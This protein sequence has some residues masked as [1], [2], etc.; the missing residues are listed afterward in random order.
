MAK[1][2]TKKN[3]KTSRVSKPKRAATAKSSRIN[4]AKPV[5]AAKGPTARKVEPK[6]SASAKGT[7]AARAPVIRKDELCNQLEKL[8][9][10][11]MTLKT[12]NRETA[13]AL[14]AAEARIEILE[15]QISKAAA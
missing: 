2:A 9:A 4:P 10:A 11:N 3:P 12:K 6:A 14:K 1:T 7:R 8:S 13:R 5:K 15:H